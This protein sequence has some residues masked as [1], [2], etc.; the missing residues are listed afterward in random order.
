ME[1]HRKYT[2]V[3]KDCFE[4]DTGFQASMEKASINL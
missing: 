4:G 3:V 2:A 1:I